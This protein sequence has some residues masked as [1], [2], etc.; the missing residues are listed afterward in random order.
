MPVVVEENA[1]REQTARANGNTELLDCHTQ[2]LGSVW[3]RDHIGEEGMQA[4]EA[5]ESIVI[6]AHPKGGAGLALGA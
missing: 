6:E 3:E 1:I 5:Q 2:A 4:V